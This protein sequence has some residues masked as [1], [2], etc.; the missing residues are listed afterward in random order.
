M[1]Y[2]K[3]KDGIYKSDKVSIV[4]ENDI[5]LVILGICDETIE[6]TRGKTWNCETNII[7]NQS[8]T[9][10]ELCGSF[11]VVRRDGT[12]FKYRSYKKA[13]NLWL[14]D[15]YQNVSSKMYGLIN[16]KRVAI[17]TGYTE[18]KNPDKLELE[19]L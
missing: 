12:T 1:K 6:R 9:I 10:E 4:K 17:M 19:L 7:I 2:I 14:S 16:G 5:E 15:G 8:D 3:T 11:E 13:F 18:G